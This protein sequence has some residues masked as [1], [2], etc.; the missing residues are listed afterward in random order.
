MSGSALGAKVPAWPKNSGQP[1]NRGFDFD[2][3]FASGELAAEH[4]TACLVF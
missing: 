2:S 4:N 3:E 1:L